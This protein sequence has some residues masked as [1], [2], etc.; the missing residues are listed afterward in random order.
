MICLSPKKNKK[1]SNIST[2]PNI[3]YN[4]KVRNVSQP[5][6]QRDYKDDNNI[7]NNME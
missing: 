7:N 4:E 5:N 2:F 1:Q 3:E 6:K